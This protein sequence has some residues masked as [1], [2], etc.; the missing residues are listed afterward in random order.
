MRVVLLNALP[1]NAFPYDH[2]AIQVHR[3]SFT[4]VKNVVY[5]VARVSVEC[6]IRHE[7]TVK[8][9]EKVL[10]LELKPSSGLYQHQPDDIIFV[11]TLKK[12]VRGA[13]VTELKEDDVEVFEVI[14]AR[15]IWL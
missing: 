10:G 12:P 3:A 1:L 6:F 11:I 15:G 13:E 8:L 14:V 9:L 2:F 7:A 5:A 4:L